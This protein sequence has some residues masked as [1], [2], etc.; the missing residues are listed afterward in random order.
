MKSRDA[1][2]AGVFC[3]V[4]PVPDPISPSKSGSTWASLDGG[5]KVRLATSVA[6]RIVDDVIALEWPVG[7]V[8]GSE[9]ELLNR[10]GVSRAVFREAVRLV[11]HQQVARMRRGPN[12]GL[13]ITEPATD[14]IVDAS[15]LYLYRADAR[16]DEVFEARL[17]LEELVTQLAPGRVDEDDLARLRE[18][19]NGEAAGIAGDYRALH[20][21]LA[22]ITKNPALE[23]FVDILNTVSLLYFADPKSLTH[24][25][26]DDVAHAHSR[27]A[28]A[29]IGGDGGL[30]RHRM[31]SHLEAEAEF[32]R[33]RRTTRQVLDPT[34][35]I[36]APDASKRAEGLAREM[37]SGIVAGRL[38]TGDLIGSEAEL[39]DRYGVSRAII[40]EAVRLLEHNNIAAMRR[41]PGGGLFVLAPSV[42]AVT[43]VVALYLEHHRIRVASL[44][45]VRMG[46]ELALIDRVIDNMD[47]SAEEQLRAALEREIAASEDFTLA[48]HDV[49]AVI[50]SLSGN[51]VLEFLSVVLIR[52]SRLHE[53]GKLSNR[54][55]RTIGSEVSHAHGAIIEAL[56]A[57]DRE[58][59]R[60]RM[61]RHLE[62]LS[63]FF[64]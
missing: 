1:G 4:M 53:L 43:D 48:A 9:A 58:L 6:D 22:A 29:V 54:S 19:V 15:V 2:A 44:F 56:I 10:Y 36:K 25:T 39:M 24:K 64:R 3:S 33:R 50:A 52:L 57:K 34:T 28:E 42:S 60:H 31:R 12:G 8:L 41:G 38:A 55:R 17:V 59:S 13:V 32:L 37:F 51:R 47:A 18:L 30:A 5:S 11:E 40:R 46:V 62:V 7:E 16:L 14:A 27:I 23:L 26:L 20:S 63:G 61:Q 35:S 21:L 45:E 49:H